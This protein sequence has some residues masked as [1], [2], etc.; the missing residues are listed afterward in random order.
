MSSWPFLTLRA[1]QVRHRKSVS[2]SLPTI[3]CAVPFCFCESLHHK[4]WRFPGWSWEPI[5]PEL[6]ISKHAADYNPERLIF[7]ERNFRFQNLRIASSFSSL[8]F[9]LTSKRRST[10]FIMSIQLECFHGFQKHEYLLLFLEET[11]NLIM[12]SKSRSIL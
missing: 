7:V 6:F 5:E 10:G 3:F 2:V 1:Q 4:K 12:I 8:L 11:T 9:S